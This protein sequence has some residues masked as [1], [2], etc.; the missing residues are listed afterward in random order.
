MTAKVEERPSFFY[1]DSR[2]EPDEQEFEIPELTDEQLIQAFAGVPWCPEP[3]PFVDFIGEGKRATAI[4][5]AVVTPSEFTEFAFRMPRRNAKGVWEYA[6]FSFDGRRHMIEP[7]DTSSRRV[8]LKCARQV[9]KST[10][11]GNKALAYS[12]MVPAY[13]TLYVSPSATQTKTFSSDRIKE[14]I[15]TSPVLKSFTTTLLAQN[16]FEKQFINRSKI[17]LRYAFLNADRTRGIPAF[18]III[19]ELQDVLKDNIPVIE[20]AASHAEDWATYEYAGTPKSLDNVIEY[21][22]SGF[23]RDKPMSTQ[24]EWMVPCDRCGSNAGAGRYWNILGEKNIGKKGLICEKC[25]ELINPMH[26][27]AQWAMQVRDG[28][29]EAYRISQLMVPWKAWEEI[30]LDY[31]RYPLPQFYNEVLGI[32]RDSGTRPITAAEVRACCNSAVRMSEAALEPYRQRSLSSPVFA[33]L[34]HGTG[35]NTY[36]L[37]TLGT[38]VDSKFRIFYAKRFVGAEVDINFYVPFVIEMCKKFNV[39]ILGADYGGGFHPNAQLTKALGRERVQQFQYVGRP[40]RRVGWGPEYLRWMVHRSVVMSSIFT[41]LKTHQ[42]ELPCWDEFREPFAQDI[43][44]IRNEYNETLRMIQYTTR[45]DRPD[46]TFHSILYCFLASMIM[47]PRTDIIAPSKEEP[48]QGPV[49]GSAYQGPLDQ[50]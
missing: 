12:C 31:G 33:G 4:P 38:Y 48:N 28:I 25:G 50:G 41:A 16:I 10:M 11:L 29:F 3:A 47:I 2:P 17:T 7:Y 39:R 27:D 42:V 1:K 15:E 24:G 46:D 19:D 9:E 30:L 40:K 18:R 8:L 22:W 20:Q 34:D 44:N 32:S 26:D 43:L 14:P 35:E 45:P 13:R 49:W 36:T 6:P 5:P 37:F 21:Y 23:S